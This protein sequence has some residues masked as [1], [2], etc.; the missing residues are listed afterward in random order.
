MDPVVALQ[1]PDGHPPAP[2]AGSRAPA[3]RT[4]PPPEVTVTVGV[5]SLMM[6]PEASVI[7]NRTFAD[8]RARGAMAGSSKI[9]MCAGVDLIFGEE[10][11]LAVVGCGLRGC[12]GEGAGGQHNRD[13]ASD[14]VSSTARRNS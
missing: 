12:R 3:P 8:A 6:I 9:V 1:D 10:I 2:P 5:R 4:L 13:G 14:A 7:R 11:A